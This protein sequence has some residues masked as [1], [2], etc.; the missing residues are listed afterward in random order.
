MLKEG[1]RRREM[2][3]G[4]ASLLLGGAMVLLAARSMAGREGSRSALVQV[5]VVHAGL[6]VAAFV[7]LKDVAVAEA[8]FQA[9]L[10]EGLNAAMIQ[11]L[12]DP[13][14]MRRSQALTPIF[15]LLM[16]GSFSALIV[17]ALTRPRARAFFREAPSGPLGEG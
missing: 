7:L 6:I 3:L 9:R 1:A 16:Q 2:P 15:G 12:G 5:V 10:V 8:A 17:L 4:A 11:R 13:E 14:A